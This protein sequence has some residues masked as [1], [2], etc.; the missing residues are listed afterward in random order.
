MRIY[1]KKIYYF[2]LLCFVSTFLFTPVQKEATLYAAQNS[3]KPLISQ[4]QAIEITI[5]A[6]LETLAPETTIQL[7]IDSKYPITE[8][9]YIA[10]RVTNI[11]DFY[12]TSKSTEITA[13]K[14]NLYSLTVTKNGLYSF[15]AKDSKGNETY[16]SK[17]VA[18]QRL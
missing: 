17:S 4:K 2:L 11:S 14:E 3:I 13:T 12:N 7:Q 16:I 6:D 1:M 9:R 10:N 8:V 15:Y 5:A 18:L